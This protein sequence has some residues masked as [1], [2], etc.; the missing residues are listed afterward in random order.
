M[1]RLISDRLKKDFDAD[2]AT[3]HLLSPPLSK[4]CLNLPEFVTDVGVFSRQFQSVF[5]TAKPY[6]GR[7]KSEQL[8]LLF[9]DHAEEVASSAL[10]PLGGPLNKESP[11][12]LLAIG[13]LDRN[14]FT[15]GTDTDFLARMAEIITAALS[16]HLKKVKD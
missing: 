4:A 14:R 6:C 5:S 9:A 8:Q 13:S 11:V 7:L 10:L 2:L 1:L 12:G 3:I 16:K 15:I